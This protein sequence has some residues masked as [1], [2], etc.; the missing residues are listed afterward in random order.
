MNKSADE[1]MIDIC[2][3]ASPELLRRLNMYFTTKRA[4]Q[5][6]VL[7]MQ[8]DEVQFRQSQ[9]AISLLKRLSQDFKP[10]V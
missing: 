5:L 4:E 2:Q 6:E 7:S 3:S 8:V 9:G 10:A 1:Q